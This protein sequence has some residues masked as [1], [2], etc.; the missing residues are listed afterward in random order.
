MLKDQ[1]LEN[2]ILADIEQGYFGVGGHYLVKIL[3]LTWKRLMPGQDAVEHGLEF[4]DSSGH[5]VCIYEGLVS[6]GH[7]LGVIKEAFLYTE[8]F[9]K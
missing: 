5:I 2:E 8:A 1:Q 3:G 6:S 7:Q 9:V 4:A